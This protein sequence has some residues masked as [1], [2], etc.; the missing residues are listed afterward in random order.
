MSEPEKIKSPPKRNM[1]SEGFTNS[2][3]DTMNGAIRLPI[4]EQ[5]PQMPNTVPRHI[6]G[7]SSPVKMYM[8][9]IPLK[10]NPLANNSITIPVVS[11][12]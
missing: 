9:Q 7:K 1:G 2:V 4:R 12:R 11:G 8:P 10:D 6:V 3:T 5:N